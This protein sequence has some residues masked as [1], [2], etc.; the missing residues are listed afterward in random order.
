MTRCSPFCEVY[1]ITI[2]I[3]SHYMWE[4]IS[5]IFDRK[6]A[7]HRVEQSPG[8][9][10]PFVYILNQ[11]SGLLCSPSLI[12]LQLA[13]FPAFYVYKHAMGVHSGVVLHHYSRLGKH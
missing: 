9:V 10:R 6:A 7:D 12:P 8:S 13:I 1:I 11:N 2:I 5:P 4:N 3:I